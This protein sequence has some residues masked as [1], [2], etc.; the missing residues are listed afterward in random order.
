[1][2]LLDPLRLF[3]S[4]RL[5]GVG[6]LIVLVYGVLYI[7][8]NVTLPLAIT[9]AGLHA[10]VYG[11]VI[12]ING[13]LIVVGQPLSLPLFER[14]PQRV[15]LPISLALVGVGMAATGLSHATWQFAVSVIIWTVGE[16]GTAGSFQALIASLAPADMR[17]RYAGALGLA[18]G[19]ADLLAPIVGASAF[20][21]ARAA[22]WIGCLVAGGLAG[23]G[24]YWLLGKVAERT[25]QE[26]VSAG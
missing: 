21:H 1:V 15:A 20:A 26:R 13:I 17:G 11:Y 18:W 23:V 16:I 22:L 10:S 24:Q 4:D 8:A 14:W 7:Q 9:S 5:L 6:T 2:R 19:A 12:A 25:A 3:R